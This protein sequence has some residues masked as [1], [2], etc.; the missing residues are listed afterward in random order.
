M[1]NKDGLEFI[2][3]IKNK[4]GSKFDT[5]IILISANINSDNVELARALG[6][7]YALKKPCSVEKFLEKVT[8]VLAK[9]RK[10]KF[11]LN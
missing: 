2:R 9:E 4:E 10:N 11:D 7:R 8:T 1:P 3:N 6:V 5:P